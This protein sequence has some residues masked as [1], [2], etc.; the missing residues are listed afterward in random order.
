MSSQFS[1]SLSAGHKPTHSA[2]KGLYNV[3]SRRPLCSRDVLHVD[4]GPEPFPRLELDVA[5]HFWNLFV[6]L[7]CPHVS[8]PVQGC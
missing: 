4:F 5:S 1:G 3:A 6:H 7:F 2:G 8:L